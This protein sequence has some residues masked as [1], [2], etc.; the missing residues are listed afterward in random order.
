MIGISNDILFPLSEQEF[1][2]AHIPHAEFRAIHSLYGHDGF[3]LEYE[4]IEDIITGFLQ[5]QNNLKF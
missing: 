5:M 2:A 4:Q 1:L 3:L